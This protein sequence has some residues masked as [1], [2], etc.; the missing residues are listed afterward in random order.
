M[1][2]ETVFLICVTLIHLAEVFPK[3]IQ[4]L[5]QGSY[6]SRQVILIALCLTVK[7]RISSITAVSVF[8]S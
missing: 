7:S 2:K 4:L 8:L 6:C 5:W 1:W 3:V